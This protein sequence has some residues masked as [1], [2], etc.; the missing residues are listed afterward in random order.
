MSLNEFITLH[1]DLVNL[2]INKKKSR[3]CLNKNCNKR[4]SY[5]YKDYLSINHIKCRKLIYCKSHKL[6]N[7]IDIISKKCITCNDKQPV[8]N[9]KD[10]KNA[11]YCGY[12]K[13]TDM[14]DIKNKKCITCNDK[15]PN[16][17]YKDEKKAV[18]WR[19]QNN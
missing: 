12:C 8:F 16:F 10:E 14:I 1:L 3:E 17:N 18:L 15:H 7:M 11:L 4:A 6:G 13:L 5:N 19:L 2:K 9:Y